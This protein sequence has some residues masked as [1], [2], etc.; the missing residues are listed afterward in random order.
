MEI[1]VVSLYEE[2]YAL[3]GNTQ[4]WPGESEDEIIVGA[5]LTQNT[6][7]S[8]V[9]KSLS[10]IR[11]EGFMSLNKL[12]VMEKPHLMEL[13]RSSGFY[14]QKARTILESTA[15]IMHS[16]GGIDDMKKESQANLEEFLRPIPGIGQETMDAILC[17][18]LDKPVFVVDKYTLRLLAR[19]GIRNAST[20]GE[21]KKYVYATIGNDLEKLKNL[22]GL[23]VNF[24]KGYC[25][26]KPLCHL[27]PMLKKCDFGSEN[28]DQTERMFP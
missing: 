3:Y 14:N 22:H 4:W 20:T 7:W 21:V 2:L 27:C 13:I 1:D 10:R 8:N 9:E 19:L 17:Y 26:S 11:D 12:A 6:A 25:R 24:A 23:I 16:F 28:K 15:R 5:I 18:A